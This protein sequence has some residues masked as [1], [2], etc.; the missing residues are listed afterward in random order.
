VALAVAALLVVIAPSGS[1]P[2]RTTPRSDG[3]QLAATATPASSAAR[4]VVT[5]E[6]HSA[7]VRGQTWFCT[8]SHCPPGPSEVTLL[9]DGRILGATH[10]DRR[11][12]FAFY[13]TGLPDVAGEPGGKVA[14]VRLTVAA[15]DGFAV[16]IKVTSGS[17]VNVGV[18]PVTAASGPGI[19]GD[20]EGTGDTSA[21]IF[22]WGGRDL[23]TFRAPA[24]TE[25]A[26]GI[27]G[28]ALS[29]DGERVLVHSMHGAVDSVVTTSGTTIG[30]FPANGGALWGDDSL[31]VCVLQLPRRV[32]SS[33]GSLDAKL[34]LV[35]PGVA[36]EL[37]AYVVVSA[38]AQM[39]IVS[40]E[41][42]AHVAVLETYF[43]GQGVAVTYV[44]LAARGP[45]AAQDPAPWYTFTMGSVELSGN[46]K[47]AVTRDGTV[48]NTS[49]GLAVGT[50]GGTPVAISWLGHD[51]VVLSGD[52]QVAEVV[53]WQTGVAIWREPSPTGEALSLLA[54]SRSGSDELA[55][56]LSQGDASTVGLW[57]VANGGSMLVSRNV[58]PGHP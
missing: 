8:T 18:P 27:A 1:G 12:R 16:S 30:S 35:D 42:A 50:V 29:P 47:Y 58:A 33:S 48:L 34:L 46:G 23:D 19:L 45:A 41:P 52:D 3:V 43:R 21:S 51:V 57:W 2:R 32:V 15:N 11:L 10:F 6:T 53:D 9:H 4:L 13:V 22:S 40:C 54:S 31:H 49:T 25:L 55:I 44:N 56:D 39:K 7:V 37:V 14:S 24:G 17:K 20:V 5:P 26:Q 28:S 38:R 36:S